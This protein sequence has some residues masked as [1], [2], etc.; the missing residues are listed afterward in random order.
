[1]LLLFYIILYSAF[2][3]FLRLVLDS[4]GFGIC[5]WMAVRSQLDNLLGWNLLTTFLL[6]GHD[7]PVRDK[8]RRTSRLIY[9]R[10]RGLIATF[11]AV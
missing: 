3:F 9:V 8:A 10:K 1:M 6:Y 5:I 4:S 2:S 7:S 11:L